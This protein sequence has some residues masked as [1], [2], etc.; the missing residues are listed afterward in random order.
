M[1]Q[2][3]ERNGDVRIIENKMTIEVGE[4]EKRLDILDLPRFG[5]IMNRFDFVFSHCETFG[6]EDITEEFNCV[7]VPFTFAG[8]SIESV[9][10]EAS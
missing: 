8:F 2:P 3:S 1:C 4:A 7:F 5:P 9:F 10:L 6:S